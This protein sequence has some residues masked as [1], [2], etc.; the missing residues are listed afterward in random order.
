MMLPYGGTCAT[1]SCPV[2]LESKTLVFHLFVLLRAAN[3]AT[4]LYQRDKMR[5]NWRD[6]LIASGIKEYRTEKWVGDGAKS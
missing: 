4:K 1:L 3:I 5:T 2:E 6:L